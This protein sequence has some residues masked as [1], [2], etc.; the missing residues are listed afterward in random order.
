MHIERQ[1]WVRG[2]DRKAGK[3]SEVSENQDGPPDILHVWDLESPPSTPLY[4]R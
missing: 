4:R 2:T 3:H 1:N